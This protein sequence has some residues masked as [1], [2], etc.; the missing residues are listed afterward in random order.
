MILTKDRYFID[1]NIIIYLFD[2][3]DANKQAIAK[4]IVKNALE[5]GNGVI[6][7]QV[8]QEF[9]NAALKKFERPLSNNDC[10]QFVNRF[11]IPLCGV[12][13]GTELYNSALDIKEKT[14]FS[15][16]DSLI[17]AAASEEKCSLIYTEDMQDGL[18]VSG[19]VIRNPF[20]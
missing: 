19:L 1:T 20:M 4:M 8:I 11:L 14:G 17:L 10:R 9:C 5:T 12:F 3:R 7:F 18:N 16:Y 2:N 6:S 13:P 15:F